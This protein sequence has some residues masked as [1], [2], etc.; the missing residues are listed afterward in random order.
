MPSLIAA[1]PPRGTT[2]RTDLEIAVQSITAT[3]AWGASP[4]SAS[5]TY[6][7]NDD[8]AESPVGVGDAISLFI[9]PD[10]SQPRFYGV[11]VS[12]SIGISSSGNER[13]MEFRDYREFLGWDVVFGAFNMEI[14]QIV[15]NRRQKRYWHI[16]PADNVTGTRT[17]T[18]FPFSA[19]Y[20]LEALFSAPTVNPI[21]GVRWQLDEL[22][23]SS[24]NFGTP[25][26]FVGINALPWAVIL[27]AP[28]YNL[29]Y[30]S[31]RT[32]GA[33]AAE[34]SERLG[35]VF[36]HAPLPGLLPRLVWV[37]KGVGPLPI[38]FNG[39]TPLFPDNSDQR[40]IGEAFSGHP[41]RIRLVGDRNMYQVLNLD[42]EADWKS[43]WEQF[44]DFLEFAADIYARDSGLEADRKTRT[45]FNAG[46][47][48]VAGVQTDPEHLIGWA[49][50]SARAKEITVRE[51]VELL[52][53]TIADPP[54]VIAVNGASLTVTTTNVDSLFADHRRFNG[55]NRMDMPAALYLQSLLYRAF[56][57]KRDPAPIIA[58]IYGAS[59]PLADVQDG[60]TH[61][62][63]AELVSRNL[64]RLTHDQVTGAISIYRDDAANLVPADGCGYAIVR[65]YLVGED[66]FRSIDP[67][68]F[69]VAQWFDKYAGTKALWQFV[70]FHVDNSGEGNQFVLFDRPV[71]FPTNLLL[72]VNGHAVVNAL[73]QLTV[74]PVKAAL[75]FAAEKYFFPNTPTG[76]RG[77]GSRDAVEN[78]GGLAGEFLAS[79]GGGV[80]LEVRY[81]DGYGVDD[82]ALVL[83]DALLARQPVYTNGGFRIQGLAGYGLTGTID[84]VTVHDGPDGRWETVDFTNE[85]PRN[86]FEPERALD[87]ATAQNSLF[88]GQQEL[89]DEAQRDR[90]IARGLRQS[91]DFYQRLQVLLS[92]RIGTTEPQASIFVKA[93]GMI[94]GATD[95]FHAGTPLFLNTLTVKE[96]DGGRP[97][98]T[99]TRAIN[100]HDDT[101]T[102]AATALPVGS[103][104]HLA[105]VTV[106]DGEHNRDAAQNDREIRVQRTGRVNVR[107]KG[108]VAKGEQVGMAPNGTPAVGTA[109][110]AVAADEI[111]L[112]QV[113]IG[114][115]GGGGGSVLPRWQ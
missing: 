6:I 29:D 50:S 111:K 21:G 31:G 13:T 67:H 52:R 106:R 7:S 81:A 94:G 17:Y 20:I 101:Q 38:A 49:D 34:I 43:G 47:V 108:P 18:D 69:N 41:S 89:R 27:Q 75:T 36:T 40:R 63:G 103:Q 64:T 23:Y 24:D 115:G 72:E 37:R 95:T 3:F 25:G 26:T 57:P 102:G 83:A 96:V 32:L 86:Y 46:G 53:R 78:I 66:L 19:A 4:G 85:R 44:A 2:T 76:Y 62:S 71:I 12:D 48:V 51:Y 28:V 98:N 105:G 14:I 109:L 58:N 33:A 1:S 39:L 79:T 91:P 77:V 82:H 70:P 42:L 100:P 60:A 61:L 16:F 35:T 45:R 110:Q 56:R 65:G 113:D 55:R 87:R 84:R 93:N 10:L 8:I 80:S 97:T 74:P 68:R 90:L 15:D 9:G 104:P 107:V 5:L 112:I 59:V 30:T 73:P 88:N 99:N 114:I 22:R 11:C 92:G 54:L